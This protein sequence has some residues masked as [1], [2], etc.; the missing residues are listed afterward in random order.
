MC[1]CK[2][3][4]DPVYKIIV[5]VLQRWIKGL[6]DDTKEELN[7]K[8]Q[9]VSNSKWTGGTNHGQYIPQLV[10][11]KGAPINST[12]NAAPKGDNGR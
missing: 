12:N 3:E 9:Y 1:K 11:A 6:E 5:G 10:G 4:H 8:G 7:L 2:D